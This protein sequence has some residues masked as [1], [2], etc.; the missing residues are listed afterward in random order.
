MKTHEPFRGKAAWRERNA[1]AE[2]PGDGQN[3]PRYVEPLN[4]PEPGTVGLP[5]EDDHAPVQEP[6]VAEVDPKVDMPSQTG[7][8]P[9][10][11]PST[12][13]TPTPSGTTPATPATPATPG[14]GKPN[15]PAA[16]LTTKNSP[17]L[18]GRP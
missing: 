15:Q 18:L 1:G 2:A 9:T 7:T 17:G 6:P 14:K 8:S 4:V 16:G 13:T 11:T 3:V 10:T 12:P 5:I